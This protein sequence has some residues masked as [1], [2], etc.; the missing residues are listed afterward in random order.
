MRAQLLDAPR[1]TGLVA[2]AEQPANHDF[3]DP[4][5]GRRKSFIT[6]PPSTPASQPP[7]AFSY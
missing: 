6:P 1:P 2:D 7:L 4:E 5:H 3:L